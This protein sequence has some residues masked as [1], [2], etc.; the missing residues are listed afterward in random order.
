MKNYLIISILAAAG[1]I[2]IGNAIAQEIHKSK[3]EPTEIQ[4]LR[5]QVKQKD[6]QLAQKDYFIAQQNFNT[7]VKELN[8]EAAKV[9]E[10][11][12][13][14]DGLVFNQEKLSFTENDVKPVPSGRVN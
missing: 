10:E 1:I 4:L 11:N 13:W 12:K 3:F 14:P 7:T 9:K 8:D 6:V 2:S 5:L